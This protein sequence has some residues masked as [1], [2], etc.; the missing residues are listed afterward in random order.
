MGRNLKACPQCRQQLGSETSGP[1][2]VVCAS[3]GHRWTMPAL[4]PVATPYLPASSAALP[5]E[6]LPIRT[7]AILGVCGGLLIVLG[8]ALIVFCFSRDEVVAS[9]PASGNE[10]EVANANQVEPLDSPDSGPKTLPGADEKK[11][12]PASSP[13][14]PVPAATEVVQASGVKAVEP[15]LPKQEKKPEPTLAGPAVFQEGEKK[16]I[17][18]PLVPTRND[19]A[20]YR[21]L[22]ST[23]RTSPTRP[24]RLGVTP[25]SFDN[26]GR[27]LMQLGDGYKYASIDNEELY[28]VVRLSSFDVVFLTCA[29]S[30]SVDSRAASGIR[31]YVEQGGTLYASDLRYDLL[32]AAFPAYALKSQVWAGIPQ[33][34]NAKVKDKALSQLIGSSIPLHFESGGWKPAAFDKFKVKV[35]IEGPYH[36]ELGKPFTA[37]LLVKFRHQ[38]G[39]VIFTSFHNAAQNSE[40]ERKLLEYLVFTAVTAQV[41]GFTAR[42]MAATGF[43]PRENKNLTLGKQT[44]KISNTFTHQKTGSVQFAIGF[45]NQGATLRLELT[46]PTGEKME[47][48][49]AAS[50][51]I[52]VQDAAQGAWRYTISSR[53]LPFANFPFTLLIGDAAKK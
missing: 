10:E 23:T 33:M 15:K 47:H 34:I 29:S 41:E 28:D 30:P 14:K 53:R 22:R 48:E 46:S 24:L 39:T 45:E 49:D 6:T 21:V 25:P 32:R 52:E 17:A 36:S 38:K 19:K 35:L 18:G 26:M 31:R 37:P 4:Y 9:L 3:C 42:G 2:E 43:T 7:L 1:G 13:A 51:I 44:D 27:L 16:F 20:K 12:K 50:F 40:L 5:W 11:A 8:V